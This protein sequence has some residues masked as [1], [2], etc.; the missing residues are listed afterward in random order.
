M[1]AIPNLSQKDDGLDGLALR[2]EE[3]EHRALAGLPGP[4]LEEFAG[5]VASTA[6]TV[7]PPS[8]NISAELVDGP[9]HRSLLVER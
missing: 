2:V 5:S 3:A 9:R 1:R 7:I 8:S 4:V 6:P